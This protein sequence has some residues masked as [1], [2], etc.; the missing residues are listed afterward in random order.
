ML[1]GSSPVCLSTQ[2]AMQW[3]QLPALPKNQP[4]TQL[5]PRTQATPGGVKQHTGV[6]AAAP[7]FAMKPV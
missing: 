1:F 3:R 4:G 2:L 7:A 6:A 5:M